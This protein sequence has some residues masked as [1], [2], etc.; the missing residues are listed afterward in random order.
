MGDMT[1]LQTIIIAI[2]E[3]LTESLPVSSTGHMIIAQ[4]LMGIESTPF[5]KAFT[6]IIQFGAILSVVVLYWKRFFRLD[7]TPAKEGATAT[8]KFLHKWDFYWKLLVAFIPALVIGGLCNGL[9]D[10]L[11][12]HVEVVA[13]MLVAGGVFMLFCDKIFNKGSEQTKITEKRAFFIGLFQCI[14]MVPGVSRSMATIVGGMAQKLTRKNAAEF[15]FFL[16]VPTMFAATVLD[17]LK[18]FLK[19]EAGAVNSS[20]ALLLIIGCVVAFFVAMAAIKG[21]ISF[22][23]KYGFQAFG[24]YRIIVGGFILAW[25]LS[26]HAMALVD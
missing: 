3:G 9:I 24:V 11:L 4:N 20:N 18:L 26:G 16:A 6:V 1:I 12:G 14:S 15:S 17:L 23:T 10:K 22:L 2:V 21:F 7:H 19:G 8:Q 25:L 5:V 13:V